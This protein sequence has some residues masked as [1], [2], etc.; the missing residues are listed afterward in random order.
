MNMN[1]AK[2]LHRE[3]AD[4]NVAAAKKKLAEL[5]SSMG[6]TLVD[7]PFQ[8]TDED[9]IRGNSID[10][11]EAYSDKPEVI[12]ACTFYRY[13]EETDA[14]ANKSL[15]ESINKFLSD[16]A[17]DALEANVEGY[18]EFKAADEEKRAKK[19]SERN[20]STQSEENDNA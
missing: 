3:F 14:D 8:S 11:C 13:V 4:K 2:R 5:A 15:M 12:A 9:V 17:E 19:E 16:D 10:I 1:V 7:N 20:E 18:K 6:V